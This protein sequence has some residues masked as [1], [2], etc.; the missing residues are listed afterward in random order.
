MQSYITDDFYEKQ[1]YDM[2][3]NWDD[4][5]LEDEE[6]EFQESKEKKQEN[7]NE[8]VEF[9]SYLLDNYFASVPSIYLM[10]KIAETFIQE[11][12]LYYYQ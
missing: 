12:S 1:E 2:Y 4:E 10:Q 3:E 6:T 7:L 11:K 5:I 8:F 9:F